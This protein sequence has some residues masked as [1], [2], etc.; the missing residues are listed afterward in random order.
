M[1]V[2]SWQGL[3]TASTTSKEVLELAVPKKTPADVL[4]HYWRKVV[5]NKQYEKNVIAIP[6]KSGANFTV[7]LLLLLLIRS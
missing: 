5:S 1:L 4:A 6:W 7:Y 3:C 2:T